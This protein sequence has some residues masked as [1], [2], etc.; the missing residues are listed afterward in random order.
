MDSSPQ[1]AL[2]VVVSVYN[3]EAVLAAFWAE[4]QAVLDIAAASRL[5]LIRRRTFAAAV[6]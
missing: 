6:V 2:S 5:F 1:P 3:E 4:L